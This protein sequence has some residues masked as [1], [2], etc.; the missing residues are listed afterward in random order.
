MLLVGTGRMYCTEELS[1][2][3]INFNVKDSEKLMLLIVWEGK[4]SSHVYTTASTKPQWVS[5]ALSGSWC[6]GFRDRVTCFLCL[7]NTDY[8]VDCNHSDWILP[9]LRGEGALFFA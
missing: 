6:L 5:A 3:Q 1:L 8:F 7:R 4:K 2:K 9:L